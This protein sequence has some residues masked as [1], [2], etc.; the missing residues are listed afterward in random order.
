VRVLTVNT[1]FGQADAAQAVDLVR[2]HRVD[3]LV[4][5]EL[6]PQ[7]LTRFRAAGIDTELGFSDLHPQGRVRAAGTGIWSRWPL[8][9][10]GSLPSAGFEMPAVTITLPSAGGAAGTSRPGRSLAVTGIHTRAPVPQ[11]ERLDGWRQDLALIATTEARRDKTTGPQL[12]VGDFNASRD[13]SGFRA[14]LATGLVDA[15]DA[16]PAAGWPGF[17]WPADR[18]GPAFTRIDHVLLTPTSIGVHDVQVLDLAGTDHHPV[19]ADLVVS[20]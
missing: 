10:Q 3:V 2:R 11:A 14:I 7:F 16:L 4:V 5:Q 8:T 20:P 13:H 19:L 15:A 1:L 18:P 6:T 17:T 12:Y 9:A